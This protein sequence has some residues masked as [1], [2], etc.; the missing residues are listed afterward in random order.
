MFKKG[1]EAGKGGRTPWM[2][3]LQ[4]WLGERGAEH[5]GGDLLVIRHLLR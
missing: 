2:S 3:S 1:K 5:R 4:E